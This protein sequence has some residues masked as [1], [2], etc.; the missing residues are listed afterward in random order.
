MI[1]GV[2]KNVPFMGRFGST[3]QRCTALTRQGHGIFCANFG[4]PILGLPLCHN[5]W[6]PPC[7]RQ[8]SGT[9]FL[10]YTGSDPQSLPSPIE[11]SYYLQAR[12][13]DSLFCP[14]ECDD[15]VFFR[16]TGGPSH[17]NNRQHQNLLDHIRRT[18]LDAF[19]SRAPGTIRDLTWMFH[20]ELKVGQTLSFCMF[21]HPMGPFPPIY[22]GG[23]RAAI[24]ILY[25]T[26]L[27]GRDE[28]K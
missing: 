26:N 4:K 21:P 14:F 28:I 24:G 8:R 9:Y 25:R 1:R 23:D 22:E 19:W 12:P 27:P 15:C 10:V 16:I 2:E 17:P 6:C 18:N 7:Y 13:G 11:V 20:E 3:W 5:A